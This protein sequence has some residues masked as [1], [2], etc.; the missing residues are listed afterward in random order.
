MNDDFETKLQALRPRAL[1]AEWK[2][3]I[4]ANAQPPGLLRSLA[5]PRW[6]AWSLAAMWLTAL[7]LEFA[8][9]NFSAPAESYQFEMPSTAHLQ[10]R[11]DLLASLSI[12]P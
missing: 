3:E 7:I 1:P 10:S 12:T 8:S 6:I 11:Q 9:P 4:L 2:A 5:P